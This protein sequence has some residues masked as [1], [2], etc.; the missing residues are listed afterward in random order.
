MGELMREQ[1]PFGKHEL[2]VEDD[3]LCIATHGT[4]TEQEMRMVIAVVEELIE[5]HGRVLVLADHREAGSFE[6]EARRFG[7]NWAV[8]K[9]VLG[10]AMYNVTLVSR[11][12]FSMVLKATNVIRKQPLPFD[13]FGSESDAREWLAALRR[14]SLPKVRKSSEQPSLRKADRPPER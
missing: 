5:R 14:Q 8:G 1:R 4:L 2:Y 6:P 12:L 7:A 11:T 3:L 13:F 9:P 10:I